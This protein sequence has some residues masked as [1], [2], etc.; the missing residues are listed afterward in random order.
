M[1]SLDIEEA[2][3][4]A[5]DAPARSVTRLASRSDLGPRPQVPSGILTDALDGLRS[6]LSQLS[7]VRAIIVN[8]MEG[9]QSFETSANSH[10]PA[11]SSDPIPSLAPPASTSGLSEA[12]TT[13]AAS[14]QRADSPN[15]TDGDRSTPFEAPQYSASTEQILKRINANAANGTPGFEAAKEQI[16]RDMAT[17]D[18]FPTPTPPREASVPNKNSKV[19]KRASFANGNGENAAVKMEGVTPDGAPSTASRGRGVGRPRGRGRGGGRGGKRKRE[20][21][22][23]GEDSDSDEISTPTALITKSGRSVQKPTAFVPPPPPS[24]TTTKKR[25]ISTGRNLENAKCKVCMRGTSP[26]S[27]MI[28]FCDGCNTPYHMYC[29][30][31]PIDKAVVEELEKEWYCRQ[32]EKVRIVPVPEAEIAGFVTANGVSAEEVSRPIVNC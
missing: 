18:K 15:K 20:D 2:L 1:P 6:I 22:S 31:P 17:S 10:A 26:Q 21:R 16:M 28:V 24:P 14:S 7:S 8:A 4:Q 11:I 29:H 9:M 23:D 12:P 13:D 27:N 19:T 30:H 3:A 32:C 25:K 5:Q